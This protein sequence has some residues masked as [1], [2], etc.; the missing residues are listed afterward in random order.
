MLY[1]KFFSAA[2]AL[3]LVAVCALGVRASGGDIAGTVTDPFG[4]VVVGAQVTATDAATQ[5]SSTA[6]TDVQG[7]YKIAGLAAGTYTVSAT[8]QGF[9]ETKQEGV[10]VEDGKTATANIQMRVASVEGSVTV[11]A[12]KGSKLGIG[13]E[14]Y[15]KLR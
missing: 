2:C 9:A 12:P 3:A 14:T 15:Q 5:K 6:T 11:T 8:A 4:A 10:R 13:D 1:R 7:H